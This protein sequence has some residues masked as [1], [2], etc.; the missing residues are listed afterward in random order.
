[1]KNLKTYSKNKGNIQL[2]EQKCLGNQCSEGL[3]MEQD[4]IVLYLKLY[5]SAQFQ[6]KSDGSQSI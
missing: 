2:F 5:L 4:E 3:A 6:G 1:M